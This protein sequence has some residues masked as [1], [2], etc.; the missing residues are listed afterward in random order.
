MFIIIKNCFTAFELSFNFLKTCHVSVFVHTFT[1][2]AFLISWLNIEL[3]PIKK[4]Y[5]YL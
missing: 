3:V 1:T 4:V 2:V 5:F